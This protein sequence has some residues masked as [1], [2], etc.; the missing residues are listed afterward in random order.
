MASPQTSY[1]TSSLMYQNTSYQTGVRNEHETPPFAPQIDF[2]DIHD[3]NQTI[4][5]DINPKIEFLG[6]IYLYDNIPRA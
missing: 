3:G 5:P 2:Y 1:S 6:D 4:K